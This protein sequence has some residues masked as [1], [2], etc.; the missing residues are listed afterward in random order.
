MAYAVTRRTREIG[1]RIALGAQRGDVIRMI[2][3]E[4]LSLIAIGSTIGVALA[5]AVSRVL[6]GFLFG[7]PPAD[8]VT[9]GST[10]VLFAAIG[11][12]ACYLPV[13]RATRIDPQYALRHQ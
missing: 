2:L 9:F 3:R 10:T 13:L 8:P 5:A 12:A 1:I 11:L 6:A 4:G 7:I